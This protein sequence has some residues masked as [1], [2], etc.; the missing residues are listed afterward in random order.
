M[1]KWI[2]TVLILIALALMGVIV[3]SYVS[4]ELA[5]GT[6]DWYRPLSLS[7]QEQADAARRADDKFLTLLSRA[8]DA[9]AAQRRTH[10][11]STQPTST[12]S[13]PITVSFSDEEL[14]AFFYKWIQL[15]H[16][17]EKMGHYLSDP[18]IILHDGQLILAGKTELGGFM[19]GTVLSIHFLPKL[20]QKGSLILE[21]EGIWAG[22]LPL[23]DSVWN[24]QRDKLESLVRAKLPQ[25]RRQSHISDSGSAN[26]DAVAVAMSDSLLHILNGKP[27]SPVIF[28]PMNPHGGYPVKLTQ[29]DVGKGSIAF[30]ALP[31][32]AEER[33]QLIERIDGK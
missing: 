22:R 24:S 31:L 14:N 21:I 26:A 13:D 6:P 32:T 16:W 27:A 7:P 17:N 20:D 10:A 19:K 9:Q 28:L 15:N 29:L 12:Q 25:L 4:Y 11:S 23:P 5:I 30:S 33:G 8:A 2:K 1:R 18:Q 3:F